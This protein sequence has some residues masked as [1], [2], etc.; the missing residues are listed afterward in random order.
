MFIHL[1]ASESAEAAK[2][3]GKTKMVQ[4]KHVLASLNELEFDW[5]APTLEAVL[6]REVDKKEAKKKKAGEETLAVPEKVLATKEG[7]L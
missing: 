6:Q 3:K 4:P 2:V 1:M 5:M 7:D